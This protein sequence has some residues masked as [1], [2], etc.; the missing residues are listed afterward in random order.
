MAPPKPNGVEI[1]H[2][3]LFESGEY[4]S[5]FLPEDEDNPFRNIYE[6]K[7][8]YVFDFAGGK[9]RRILDLGGGYGR[10]SASLAGSHDVVLADLSLQMLRRAVG[11]NSQLRSRVMNCDAEMLPFRSGQ[12]D[13]VLALDLL[14]HLPNPHSALAEIRRVLGPEGRLLVDSSNKDPWWMLAYPGYVHPFRHPFRFIRTFF[15]GGVLPE[16]QHRVWHYRRKDFFG[17]LEKS[18][19]RI[20]DRR[21]FGPGYCPKWHLVICV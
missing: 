15:G 13:L 5:F 9:R 19:F 18:G 12:F 16:W 1:E 7:R 4:V 6:E 14:C 21:D 8:R 20:V 11:N 17:L 2:K 10:H 3:R